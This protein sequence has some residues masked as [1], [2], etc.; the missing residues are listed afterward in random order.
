MPPPHKKSFAAEQLA[1]RQQKKVSP[2]VWVLVGIAIIALLAGG[3]VMYRR[4]VVQKQ[5]ETETRQIKSI[6][7]LPLDNMSGDPDQVYFTDGMH[8]AL[9]N[10]LSKIGALRVIS[11]TSVMEYRETEKKVPEIARELGVDAVIEGSVYRADNQVRI[12][13]QLIAVEPEQHLWS[14]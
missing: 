5:V 13:V 6:A 9:I 3:Y 2:V 8:E 10:N 11:R 12:T 4:S 1:L 7:V 14:N